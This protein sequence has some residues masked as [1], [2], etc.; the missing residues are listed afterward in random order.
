MTTQV[1]FFILSATPDPILGFAEGRG[2]IIS[3][4]SCT[5]RE[6]NIT[7]CG[8]RMGTTDCH[9]GRDVAIRCEGTFKQRLWLCSDRTCNFFKCIRID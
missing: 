5:S 9:H 7:E 3:H 8:W 1:F 2:P 6:S 4:L